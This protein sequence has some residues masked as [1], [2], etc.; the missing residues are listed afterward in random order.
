[1]RG[2]DRVA[3]RIHRYLYTRCRIGVL[4]MRQNRRH[5][6]TVL[7]YL[8]CMDDA[9]L[10]CCILLF[11]R[12]K[13]KNQTVRDYI[14]QVTMHKKSVF[15]PGCI[16]VVFR[17]G[18]LGYLLQEPTEEARV[19][20]DNPALQDK[21]APKN[22]EL[23]RQSALA[24]VRQRGVD[25]SDETEVLGEY[26]L[27]FGKYKGKS[28]RWLLENDM[29]YTIYLIKNL[30]QEE[31]M[32]VFT[33]EG[34]SKSSLLSF[35]NYARSFNEIQSLLS[36]VSKNP[37]APAASSEG[38]QLVGFGAHAKSTWQEIWNNRADGYASFIL[39]ATCVPGTRMY[40]RQQYLRNQVQSARPPVVASS[41]VSKPMEMDDDDKLESAMLNISPS[42]LQLQSSRPLS[43]TSSSSSAAEL[44]RTNLLYLFLLSA[45]ALTAQKTHL[46]LPKELMF[47]VP[48][49]SASTQSTRPVSTAADISATDSSPVCRT[50][51]I[52]ECGKDENLSSSDNTSY[53]VLCTAEA[54]HDSL[55]S[56]LGSSV[57]SPPPP[58]QQTPT[59]VSRGP[60]P[61]P[62][63]Y[64]YD[65]REWKCSHQQK[66]WMK[67][68]LES[69]GLWPGSPPL[70]NPMKTVSLWRLPP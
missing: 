53:S 44:R 27:Q 15:F 40:K 67:T 56:A 49:Q 26:I 64:D 58:L 37:G 34:P 30:Q 42:K 57:C 50:P 54:S 38:D 32:G 13:S 4:K 10:L 63:D 16:K 60:P 20:S 39:G 36:Y 14:T 46:V 70:S 52:E 9:G 31:A 45:P 51:I 35:S 11:K 6:C 19:I 41:A 28:F 62:L 23:V 22:E 5:L 48:E 12:K 2:T 1:M 61:Q 43:S 17:K 21:S 29:G 59:T 18:P 25:A 55:T 8:K 7:L 3:V 66:I 24:V 69:M 33:A 68:E 65:V 47:L